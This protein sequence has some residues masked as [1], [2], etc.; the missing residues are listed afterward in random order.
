[1][2]RVDPKSA[3]SIWPGSIGYVPQD[4]TFLNG[5]VRENVAIAVDPYDV[6]DEQIWNCLRMVQL[7]SLFSSSKQNPICIKADYKIKDEKRT[8]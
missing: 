6:D 4:V 1:V 2:S 3:I 8:D 7:D 5:S